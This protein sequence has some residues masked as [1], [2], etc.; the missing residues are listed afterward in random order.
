MRP[1]ATLALG[2]AL[3]LS[4]ISTLATAPWVVAA[5]AS[6]KAGAVTPTTG[7]N[8]TSFLFSVHFQ[9]GTETAISASASVAGGTVPLIRSGGPDTNQVW[10]GSS[11]LPVGSWTVVFHSVSSGGTNP[12]FVLTTPVVVTPRPCP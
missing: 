5:A 7:T 11:T 10:S 9:P 2:L 4:T 12:Q 3:G 1:R 8:T 6:L